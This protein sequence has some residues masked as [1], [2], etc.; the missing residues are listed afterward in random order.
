[1][2]H[3]TCLLTAP[4]TKAYIFTIKLTGNAN[5]IELSYEL[6]PRRKGNGTSYAKG[7]YSSNFIYMLMP[8]RFSNGDNS[9]DRVPGMKDQSLNRDSIF[10]R[11]GGDLQGVIN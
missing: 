5:T 1:N 8:D 4:T 9:N 10:L 3:L 6:L 7:V 2:Y 11:H